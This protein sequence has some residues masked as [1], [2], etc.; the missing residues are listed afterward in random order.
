LTFVRVWGIAILVLALIL[1]A[2]SPTRRITAFLIGDVQNLAT[3]DDRHIGVV[4]THGSEVN[5]HGS[6]MFR[7]RIEVFA[8][9]VAT[10]VS[11]RTDAARWLPLGGE[12]YYVDLISCPLLARLQI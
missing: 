11:S 4:A 2:A 12:P 7:P 10:L 5:S 6:R 1:N 9:G 3:E 8:T